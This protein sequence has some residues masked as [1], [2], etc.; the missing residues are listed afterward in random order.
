MD[1]L[2]PILCLAIGVV[3]DTVWVGIF[4]KRPIGNFKVL[5]SS[6]GTTRIESSTGNFTLDEGART[7]RYRVG[8]TGGTLAFSEIAG[9]EYRVNEKGAVLAELVL[10]L[11]V[12][13]LLTKYRDTV[14]WF[15]IAVVAHDGRRVPL[16]LSGQYQPRE[17]L[18]GWYI[19]LQAAVLEHLGHWPDVQKDSRAA[20]D[21]LR[22]RLGQPRLL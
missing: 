22:P 10:G 16:Y 1:F 21:L 7:L 6:H 5:A 12:T 18:L 9:L 14:E 3:V 11:N 20:L 4:R 17:F 2:V 15:S 8:G 19:E 13:D